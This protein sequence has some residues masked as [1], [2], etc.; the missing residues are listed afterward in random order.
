MGDGWW[1]PLIR[2]GCGGW[3]VGKLVLKLNSFGGISFWEVKSGGPFRRVF[4]EENRLEWSDRCTYKFKHCFGGRANLT[5][6]FWG[7]CFGGS[8]LES[9]GNPLYF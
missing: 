2:V 1:E 7:V 5:F 8:V 9:L 4:S 3:V 6:K